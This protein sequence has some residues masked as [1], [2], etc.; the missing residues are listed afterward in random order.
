MWRGAA[1]RVAVSPEHRQ[2]PAPAGLQLPRDKAFGPGHRTEILRE[3]KAQPKHGLK[4][5]AEAQVHGKQFEEA[6]KDRVPHVPGS[7][8]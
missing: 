4:S 7:Y 5:S 8:Q 2:P 3:W 6:E 1:P